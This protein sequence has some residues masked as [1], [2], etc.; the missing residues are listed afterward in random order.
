MVFLFFLTP[1]VFALSVFVL[2]SVAIQVYGALGLLSL[3]LLHRRLL[4]LFLVRPRLLPSPSP[5]PESRALKEGEERKE[6][7]K[8]REEKFDRCEC[9]S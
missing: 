5:G 6:E 4:R 8:E 2:A 1:F 9:L 7:E 3:L